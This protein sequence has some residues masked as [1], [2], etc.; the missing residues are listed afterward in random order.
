MEI[1][2]RSKRRGFLNTNIVC[3]CGACVCVSL[4]KNEVKKGQAKKYFGTSEYLQPVVS[5]IRP[6][7]GRRDNI[8]CEMQT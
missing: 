7:G 1:I 3:V 4:C 6:G 2:I 8:S 5:F